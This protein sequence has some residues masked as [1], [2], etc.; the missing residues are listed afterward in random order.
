MR[1]FIVLIAG[2][3][4]IAIG[5]L[6][7]YLGPALVP[8]AHCGY[9]GCAGP[10]GPFTYEVPVD[11]M[12]A[13]MGGIV[14]GAAGTLW[15]RKAWRRLSVVSAVCGALA[16][17]LLVPLAVPVVSATGS[18]ESIGLAGLLS[19][20]A[21]GTAVA[22]FIRPMPDRLLDIPLAV[23]GLLVGLLGILPVGWILL[24]T[25]GGGMG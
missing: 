13:G 20:V 11:L 23:L 25:V 9:K 1:W 22:A 10:P 24:I 3:L 8:V 4:A 19:L 21:I 18:Y 2:A 17:L 15:S 16:A 14:V 5:F 7:L 6:M 12:Q